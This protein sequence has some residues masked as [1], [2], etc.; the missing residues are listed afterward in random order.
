[1]DEAGFFAS[2]DVALGVGVAGDVEPMASPAFAV[3]GGVE[4]AVNESAGCTGAVTGGFGD[5]AVDLGGF[6]GKAGEIEAEAS[7]EGV[8]VGRRGGVDSG[9]F[10]PG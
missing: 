7:D 3:P 10:E 9:G 6:G 2:V 1:M 5:E 4:Q 8:W